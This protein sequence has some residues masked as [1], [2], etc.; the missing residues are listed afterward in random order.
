MK[1]EIVYKIR[2][3]IT[4]K[5]SMG[6][7][8]PSFSRFANKGGK[9]WKKLNHLRLH[10]LQLDVEELKNYYLDCVVEE[11]EI[12]KKEETNVLDFILSYMVE[13]KRQKEL[14]RIKNE[15]RWKQDKVERLRKELKELENV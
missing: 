14:Q 3:M 2:N 5:Y 11:I 15:V 12:R 6:G 1:I 10:F 9:I 13:K 7:D 8:P 4:N